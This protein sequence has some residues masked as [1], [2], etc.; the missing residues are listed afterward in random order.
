MNFRQIEIFKAVM[1]TGTV[2]G[3]AR[4]LHISQ[5]AV[6]KMLGQ[7]ERALGFAAFDRLKGRLVPTA[8]ARALYG[9][10]ERA[11][12]GMDYLSRFATD[13]R[14]LRR[15]HL[16]VSVLPTLS[17]NW[18]PP[19]VARFLR[20]HPGITL[21]LLT[22]TSSKVMEW[23]AEQQVDV[24]IAMLTMDDPMV[25]HELLWDCEAVC[26]LPAGH[27][28]A[29]KTV[30][31][32]RDLA[33]EA[34]ISLSSTDNSRRNVDRVLEAEGVRARVVVD[35]V[36]AATAC[37]LVAQGVGISIVDPMT[38]AQYTDAGVVARRFKPQVTFDFQLLRPLHRPRAQVVDHFIDY[39]KQAV[40][41]AISAD[42]LVPLPA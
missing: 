39:L 27:P 20:D 8:E 36:L 14:E 21:S 30:I 4:R 32:A 29:E 35:T 11:Y 42:K 25:E 15:G 31:E 16:V 40:P 17:V 23:V 34:F 38:A 9:Q 22:R 26:V 19:I 18:M 5:P 41:E 1:E 6:S 3:A 13:L 10:I 24:G 28:L 33:D 7:L 37:G 2:T 12:L